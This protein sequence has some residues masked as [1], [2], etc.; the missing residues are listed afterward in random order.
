MRHYLLACLC[1][2]S[3]VFAVGLT[4][5]TADSAIN[6]ACIATIDRTCHLYYVTDYAQALVKEKIK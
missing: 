1:I 4:F 5:F 6:T 3:L 2:S